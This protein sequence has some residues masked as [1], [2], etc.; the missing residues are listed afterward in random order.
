MA[1][2]VSTELPECLAGCM[3]CSDVSMCI[4]QSEGL[5]EE[6]NP[7]NHA[8]RS[9]V[10]F[11]AWIVWTRGIDVEI[12]AHHLFGSFQRIFPIENTCRKAN[13][14]L[15]MTTSSTLKKP[16]LILYRISHLCKACR[17]PAVKFYPETVHGNCHGKCREISGEVLLLLFPQET[18]FEGAQKFSRQISRHF[19]RDVLQLQMPNFMAFFTLQTFVLEISPECLYSNE[20]PNNSSPASSLGG[21]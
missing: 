7:F 3:A 5:A 8:S 21:W 19:S 14:A 6:G 16:E 2:E 17:S 12:A 10:D 18:K 4:C 13:K 11:E 15:N 20:F 1:S 9:F